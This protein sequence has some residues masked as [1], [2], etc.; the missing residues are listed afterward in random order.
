MLSFHKLLPCVVAV[1]PLGLAGCGG[2]NIVKVTGTLTHKGKPVPNAL[3]TFEPDHG[4]QSWAQT[5]EAGRFKIFYDRQQ[6]GA[7]VGKHKVFIEFKPTTDAEREAMLVGKL[8]P[9][10]PEMKAFFNKYSPRNS[11]L[12]V[13]ITP[14]NTDLKLDLD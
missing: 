5:D 1:L 2:S 6:D 9:Q 4:R 7:I 11:K 10:S 14:D 3:L 12:T 8:P 13:E